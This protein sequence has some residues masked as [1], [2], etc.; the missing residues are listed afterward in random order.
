MEN[1]GNGIII[2]GV[3]AFAVILILGLLLTIG[4]VKKSNKALNDEKLRSEQLASDKAGLEKDIEKLN[5]D[6][7]AMKIKAD[8][9]EKLIAE[10][11]KKLA[12]AERRARA[13]A[14]DSKALQTCRKE[15]E[16]LK[17][18]KANLEKE[19]SA[20][21]AEYD[22]LLA[23]SNELQAANAKLDA[24]K[25]DLAAKL[26]HAMTYDFDNVMVTAVRGKSTEKLVILARR[27]K[28]INITFDVPKS[29]TDDVSFK[30]T[31]PGGQTVTTESGELNWSFPERPGIMTASL[32]PVTGEFEES[33]QVNLT[34]TPSAKLVPGIYAIE[35]VS[36]GNVIGHC[37]I[38]LR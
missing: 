17:Q 4:S 6:L 1:K 36:K 28:K 7:S 33:R 34:Y 21:K 27:T 29:L 9:N 3:V 10:T 20:L 35:L 30:I 25:K 16:E 5:A 31:T 32:S 24:E 12:D 22:K 38:K 13:L 26:E 18:V 37:R 14:A 23:R 8:E 19:S 15:M 2:G 11:N